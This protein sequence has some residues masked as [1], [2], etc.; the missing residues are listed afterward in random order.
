MTLR[1]GNAHCF[2]GA[3][4]AAAMLQ[5]LGLR[6]FLIHL[7]TDHSVDDDH[8]ITAYMDPRTM[9]WGSVAKVGKDPTLGGVQT[10]ML[11]SFP[12]PLCSPTSPASARDSPCMPR[13]ASWS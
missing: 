3:L 8:V 1:R 6:P 4:L 5:H 11:A 9:L 10:L 12:F 2:G 13:C 7:D